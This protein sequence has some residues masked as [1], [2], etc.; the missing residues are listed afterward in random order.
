MPMWPVPLKIITRRPSSVFSAL[1]E[2]ATLTHSPPSPASSISAL[3]VSTER[4]PRMYTSTLPVKPSFFTHMLKLYVS[5][6]SS[7]M[8]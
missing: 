2:Q 1:T 7:A 6:L 3:V 8:P 5:P 4:A